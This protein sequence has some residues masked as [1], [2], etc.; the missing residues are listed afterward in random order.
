MADRGDTHYSVPTLNKWFFISSALLLVATFWMVI[1]DWNSPWKTYQAEFRHIETVRTEEAIASEAMQAQALSAAEVEGRLAEAEAALA[2]RNAEVAETEEGLR[3]A[4]GELFTTSESTKKAK[5]DLA[6]ER[7]L[8]EEH[9]VHDNDPTYGAERLKTFEDAFV[10]LSAESELKIA[11]VAEW[12]A[13]LDALNANVSDLQRQKKAAKID[14]DLLE[15]K[16][17]KLAPSSGAGKLANFVRD[18]PGLDFVDP[19]NKVQKQVLP[20]LTF[21]LNFTKGARIDM[22][23][24][25]HQASDR[26]GY[27]EDVVVDGEP[28]D[29]PYLSHPRLDLFLTAKSPH[30]VSKVGCTICH[31]GSGQALDFI[32]SDHR[33][34]M[35]EQVGPNQ[36]APTADHV[37]WQEEHHWHKQHHW[38]YPMLNRQNVEASCVQCHKGS[39]ELIADDAPV[40]SRGYQLFEE[41]G[42]YSCHKVEWYPTKRAP[43][44]SLKNLQA[45]LE[46]PWLESWISNPRDFRPDTKMPRFFHLD[47]FEPEEEI[48][49][50]EWG[51]GRMILGDEWNN[52][53]IAAIA[54][55]LVDSAPKQAL[56]SIP[57]EA[58]QNADADRGRET[59]RLVGCLSCH[60][61]GAYPGQDLMT[62]DPAWEENESNSHGPNL[63][64]V[65][66]KLNRTW[67]YN[68]LKDPQAY[69]PE[70]RMPNLRLTDLQAAD[71]T[72]YIMD[73]P[74]GVFTDTTP[75][76]E[77][78]T[79]P[80]ELDVLQEMA[81]QFFAREG[82]VELNRRFAGENPDYAWND[83]DEL[84]LAVGEKQIQH[85]GCFSCHNINGMEGMNPIGVELT[86]WGSKTVDKLAWEFRANILADAN[87]WDLHTRE[88]FKHYRE[89]WIHE[90]LSNTRVF[91][92]EKVRAPLERL[93]MPLF[94]LTAED[95]QAITT[96]VVG[97]VDDEVEDAKM[98]PTPEQAA[99][100]HGMRVVRQNNCMACHVIEPAQ[101][102]YHDEDGLL[103][104]VL[105]E[106]V[107]IGDA[108]VPPAMASLDG[109]LAEIA[110]Y[111]A[112]YGEE[113]EDLGFRLLENA[114]GLGQTGEAVF[115]VPDQIVSIVP[116]KGGDFVRTVV[117]YY[118]NGIEMHDPSSN[119]L[120]SWSLGED[121]AV[122]DVDGKLRSYTDKATDTVRWAFAPPVLLNEGGKLQRDWF[123]SFLL[124]PMPLRQQ[125][126]V[127]MPTFNLTEEEAGAIADYF[128]YKSEKN[129]P[130]RY[131]R[132]AH[133]AAGI[134]PRRELEGRGK[135]WPE[136]SNLIDGNDP[137][138][139]ADAAAAIGVK[140]D[141]LTA[142]EEGYQPDIDANFS[143]VVK[144]AEA[145]GFSMRG[146]VEPGL[147]RIDQR[148]AS[149]HSMFREGQSVAA[150]GVNCFKCHWLNGK[151][152]DQ[153]D[154]PEAWAP[155]L[156]LA[157]ER[158]RP[159][160]TRDWLWN[161]TLI[162]PGTAMAANFA[163]AQPDYQDQY[164]DSTNAQQ[165]EAVLDWLF[166]M[167]KAELQ[168]GQ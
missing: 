160:W 88:E 33:P 124:D 27:T 58:A 2:S 9:R 47:N 120:V 146:P 41:N 92:E 10:A 28:L 118:L 60:N 39:M 66:T 162:Y 142:M 147:E 126:R 103:V 44:P 107:P 48:V 62:S 112:D 116:A 13:Q 83:A 96:F 45:K 78:E 68:W 29:H 105:A 23:Q 143:K 108:N 22:C 94:N 156:G 149:Y 97:L 49:Q 166:T 7:F 79:R 168:A 154:A 61:M 138:S 136:L 91:D 102:T 51:Q 133:L 74:D 35:Y 72:S 95:K 55:Y 140:P 109:L 114:P 43:G 71:I 82:R 101:V 32:R 117:D 36:L 141:G 157:R 31:R 89:N 46:R 21:E 110:A 84:L 70:T 34:V 159:D 8:I 63:R 24:T 119:E 14:L 26:A 53:A 77:E 5:Q 122:M 76:W 57:G 139:V 81:R 80:Y 132:T 115:V 165:I 20:D 69:W 59:F 98:I 134:E 148:A 131:T 3:Q 1:D 145:W 93:R 75:V 50:S 161:P 52:N 87:D 67:L 90:K 153:M 113:V 144:W 85:Y 99:M 163:S 123:Y 111:E 130:M 100:D 125:L 104:T 137:V 4:K 73:D 128:A 12:Q 167:D 56:P 18:F 11:A 65:A 19:K 106:P 25:C 17:E 30:P 6:W 42:C 64:G 152:P 16:L 150:K 38:D 40:V 15:K 158:L 135:P 86:N 151:G 127:K 54:A 155:N 129:W 37:E 121:G 164:P